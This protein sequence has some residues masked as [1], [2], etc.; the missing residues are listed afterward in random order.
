[1]AK[2]RITTFLLSLF[3]AIIFIGSYAAFNN[4]STFGTSSASTTVQSGQTYFVTGTTN[5]VVTGYGDAADVLI[6]GNTS[7]TT[8]VGNVLQAMQAN[9]SIS[10]YFPYGSGYNVFLNTINAYSLEQALDN[11]TT[12]NTVSVNATSYVTLPRTVLMYYNTQQI[13]V[14]L[15]DQNYTMTILPLQ[16]VG[17]N[18]SVSVR[19]LVTVN[20]SIYNN[21]VSVSQ[22]ASA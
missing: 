17:S 12:A 3:V 8:A 4:N 22:K 13:R 10:S 2:K 7:A 6:S 9:G 1:M 14:S 19:A 20:G 15:S 16:M 21:Q 11:A 18:V 5:A